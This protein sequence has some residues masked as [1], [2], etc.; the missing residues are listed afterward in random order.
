MPNISREAERDEVR[1]ANYMLP[2]TKKEW[3]RWQPSIIDTVGRLTLKEV[4]KL[5]FF[6]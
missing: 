1:G 2:E 4:I 5:S 6:I 3:A